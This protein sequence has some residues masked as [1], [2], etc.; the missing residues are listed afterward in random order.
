M[1]T[2]RANHI[3]ALIIIV[4]AFWGSA[5]QG[6]ESPGRRVP[7]PE[8]FQACVGKTEGAFVSFTTRNETLT[9]TCRMFDGKLAAAPEKNRNEGGGSSGQRPARPAS[10]DQR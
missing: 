8:A 7:P 1:K 9:A 4:S 10:N 3:P 2:V 5:A 6:E